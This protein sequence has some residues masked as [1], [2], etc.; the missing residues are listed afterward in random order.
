MKPGAN[1]GDLELSSK[2]MQNALK[3]AA[4]GSIGSYVGINDDMLNLGEAESFLDESEAGKEFTIRF[5]N[6][7]DSIQ[8]I[9]FNRILGITLAD[10]HL[11]CQGHVVTTGTSGSEKYL[12]AEGDP[13]S[14]DILLALISEAPVRVR[15]I[16]FNVS[17]ASQLDEPIKYTVE[18][19]FKTGMTE[20]KIPSTYQGQ[21]TNNTKTVEVDFKNW[22][23][24]FDSTIS[25][26]IRSGVS[27]SMTLFLGASV[28]LSN[29]L[30]VKHQK[31]VKSAAQ[32][33]ARM[34]N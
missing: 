2:E 20:Q 4:D 33:V 32:Y 8:R 24:G 34:G 21:D 5:V 26:A 28:D 15:K 7:T 17:D 1:V 29:A 16:K 13:R 22:I 6:G 10:H 11:L 14:L 12:D 25:Y 23:L 30:R 27:V 31:A 18:T 3:A 9:Q 19:P